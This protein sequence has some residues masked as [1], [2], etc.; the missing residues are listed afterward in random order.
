MAGGADA[1]AAAQVPAILAETVLFFPTASRLIPDLAAGAAEGNVFRAIGPGLKAGPDLA[2]PQPSAQ[3]SVPQSAEGETVAL[4]AAPDSAGQSRRAL[5]EVATTLELP[6]SQAA[7]LTENAPVPVGRAAQDPD[8]VPAAQEQAPHQLLQ[9][10]PTRVGQSHDMPLSP[11]KEKPFTGE[12]EAGTPRRQDTAVPLR[13]GPPPD[14]LLPAGLTD[15][16]GVQ[17]GEERREAPGAAAGRGPIPLSAEP[18]R[19][20]AR[21]VGRGQEGRADVQPVLTGSASP[22]GK[23]TLPG[24]KDARPLPDRAQVV[25][26][27]LPDGRSD[28]SPALS[29]GP[30]LTGPHPLRPSGPGAPL[31]GH[32]P[33]AIGMQLADRMPAAAGQP[34]EI[35]LAPEE[36]GKVRMTL[37]A[38][39][40]ALTLQLVADRP[41]TLDLMRRHIDQLA[42]DFR[43]MGFERLSFAFGQ[44]QKENQ[45]PGQ[46]APSDPPEEETAN[47]VVT[48]PATRALGRAPLLPLMPD[49][50][51]DLRF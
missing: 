7:R 23:D 42:Q 5:A 3:P 40:G 8:A 16:D 34:V 30:D 4:S 33:H 36:L 9:Q 13:A 11:S 35:T 15:P 12:D 41:E 14:R 20:S 32:S 43:D 49:D 45:Q 25:P 29:F 47:H 18:A 22:E 48:V 31:I 2:L 21:D 6:D 17:R 19:R 38:T 26:V 50:R 37:S 44:G 28:L 51:L 39:E 27:G 24:P 1:D 46:A 10:L